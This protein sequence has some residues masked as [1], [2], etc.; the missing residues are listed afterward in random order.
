MQARK[1]AA[2]R[3]NDATLRR[4]NAQVCEDDARG[5]E[6][7]AQHRRNDAG[8]RETKKPTKGELLKRINNQYIINLY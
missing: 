5:R 2:V 4:I 7:H 6:I 3:E 8:R 1:G